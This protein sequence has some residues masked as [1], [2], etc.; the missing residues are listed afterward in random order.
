MYIYKN[1][2]ALKYDLKVNHNYSIA[3]EIKV[4]YD[5]FKLI[6]TTK[7][8]LVYEN[9]KKNKHI[10][11]RHKNFKQIKIEYKEGDMMDFFEFSENSIYSLYMISGKIIEGRILNSNNKWLLIEQKAG[12]KPLLVNIH[13]IEFLKENI[14]EVK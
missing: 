7:N 9:K 8:L 6:A 11:I 5:L 14:E 3:N 4:G 13:N 10:L 2:D 12:E 1:L